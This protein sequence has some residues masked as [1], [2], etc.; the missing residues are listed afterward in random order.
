MI[1]KIRLIFKFIMTQ[2]GKQAIAIH[3]LPIISRSKG[4]QTIKFGKP[5]EYDTSNFLLQKSYKNV[6]EK[7]LAEPFLKNRN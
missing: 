4:N 2:L 7:P 3:T 6:L 1:T 5:I